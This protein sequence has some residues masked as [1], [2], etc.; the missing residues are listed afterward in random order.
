M[1][2]DNTRYR[3]TDP[4]G[5]RSAPVGTNDPLAELARLIGKEGLFA[6]QRHEPRAQAYDE[7]AVHADEGV[8]R[9]AVRFMML[10]RKNDAAL[11]FDLAKVIEQSRDNPV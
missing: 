3:T 5:G 7:R 11:D 8:Y 6:D 10:Y 2:D 9:D 1:A 4:L